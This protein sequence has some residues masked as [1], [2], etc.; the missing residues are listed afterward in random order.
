M[1]KFRQLI[2]EFRDLES[3][4]KFYNLEFRYL[5]E[6]RNRNLRVNYRKSRSN[7]IS[8]R[9]YDNQTKFVSPEI[10]NTTI[11]HIIKFIDKMP[12]RN[13]DKNYNEPKSL[14]Q[15]CGLTKSLKTSHCF[16]DYT[17]QTCCLLGGKARKYAD[18]TGNPIGKISSDIFKNYFNRK[19]RYNDLT[20]WCTCIGSK[21]CSFYADKFN[22][23]THIKFI[24][25][26]NTN[27]ILRGF[28]TKCEENI[29]HKLGY[30]AHKTPGIN[31]DMFDYDCDYNIYNY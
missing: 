2:V 10:N 25:K 3:L 30:P 31:K 8:L 15:L 16:N 26:K 5:K 11:R 13:I 9:G 6:F 23:G 17:H 20:P 22:D 28:K 27:F 4:N 7:K 24:N 14:L 18:M 29:R 19:P 1:N 12:M 21:V